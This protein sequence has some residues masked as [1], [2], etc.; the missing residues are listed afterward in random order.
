MKCRAFLYTIVAWVLFFG[1]FGIEASIDHC[2]RMRDG[3]VTTGGIPEPLWF[4]MQILLGITSAWLAWIATETLR[5]T[6]RRAA[7]VS[8]Q[9]IVGFLIYAALGLA[10]VVGSGI[11][12]L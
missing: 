5:T 6:W 7:L 2:L 10:Y 4:G 1:G 9:L 3:N 12:S 8:V 11:D